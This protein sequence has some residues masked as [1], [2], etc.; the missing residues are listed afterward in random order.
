MGKKG[1]VIA[2]LIGVLM[3]AFSVAA[4]DSV[5]WTILVYMEADNNLEGDALADILEMEMVGSSDDVNIVVQIDRAEAYSAGDG[6]WT[7]ARRYLLLKNGNTGSLEDIVIAKFQTPDAIRLGTPP[8]LELGEINNGDPQSLIDFIVW[9]AQTYPADKLGLVLWNHGGTWIGGFGGDE[10]TPNHDG[11]DL[12]EL[13]AALAL[14]TEEI[15]QTFEIIGFDTCLMGQYEI[16]SILSRYANYAVGSEELEPGFGWYYTPA[17][18]ALVDNPNMNGDE[19]GRNLVTAYQAFYDEVWVTFTGETYSDFYGG[20]FYGQTAADLSQMEALDVALVNFSQVARA[21]MDAALVAAIGDAHNNTQL[22][23]NTSPDERPVTASADLQHFM[24]LLQRF[25]TNTAVNAAAADVVARVQ[26]VVIAH[27]ATNM[28]GAR[29]L[30]IYFPANR[31]L[32]EQQNLA[33]RYAREAPYMEQW[34]TFLEAF[35]DEASASAAQSVGRVTVTDVF[36][37]YDV[38]DIFNPPTLIFE[39]DGTNITDFSFDAVLQLDDGVSFMVDQSSLVSAVITEDGEPIVDIPDGVSSST[40]TWTVD[41]PIITDGNVSVPTVLLETD[42]EDVVVVTGLYGFSNGETL[43]AYLMFDLESR[44]VTKVW[45]INESENGGQPFE[46][47]VQQGDGFLP[48]WRYYDETGELQFTTAEDVLIFGDAP[49][50][51]E[52]IPA[53]SGVYDITIRMA[54]IAG[55]VYSDTTQVTVENAAAEDISYR[56]ENNV[57]NGYR[58]IFPFEWEGGTDVEFD[59]GSFQ[60]MY[61]DNDG[62]LTLYFNAYDVTSLEEITVIGEEY[63]DDFAIAYDEP[64]E[65]TLGGYD[66][67]QYNYYAEGEDGTEFGGLVLVTY[68]DE[69]QIGYVIDFEVYG[70]VTDEIETY[71]QVFINTL[72]FFEPPE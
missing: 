17:L 14:A 33:E 10:S 62:V 1:W 69:T 22:F 71:Y 45:G 21:N 44:A 63:L 6:D 39:S 3:S 8:L 28:P 56:G 55:N 11:I 34:I 52:Y 5:S 16:F 12:L 60:T 51:F 23:L 2:L 70:E 35:Y 38:V 13:D 50:T 59:D 54:D 15:G 25:S 61:A 49:F 72:A 46:I 4:Q 41:M 42:D 48:T 24:E 9:G 30:S 37:L 26:D 57:D 66:A 64:N 27:E 47:N 32:Y 65:L 36:S 40:Y 53:V 29:G 20:D 67:Y 58:V 31:R 7:G 43:D 19:L 68:V 18:Q